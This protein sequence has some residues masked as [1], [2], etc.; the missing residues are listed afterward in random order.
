MRLLQRIR[1][2]SNAGVLAASLPLLAPAMIGCS[3]QVTTQDPVSCGGTDAGQKIPV[4]DRN[5]CNVISNNTIQPWNRFFVTDKSIYFDYLSDTCQPVDTVRFYSGDL[6]DIKP[7]LLSADT[8]Y[9]SNYSNGLL[10]FTPA[11]TECAGAW[12]TIK[13]FDFQNQAFR[14]LGIGS[15]N[16]VQNPSPA[17]L[18][19]N[20]LYYLSPSNV[21]DKTDMNVYD[22][23]DGSSKVIAADSPPI[24]MFNNPSASTKGIATF[25]SSGNNRSVDFLYVSGERKTLTSDGDYPAVSVGEDYL[26]VSNGGQTKVTIYAIDDLSPVKTLDAT[27]AFFVDNLLVFQNPS[28]GVTTYEP[29]SDKTATVGFDELIKGC[30]PDVESVFGGDSGVGMSP[31]LHLFQNDDK[32]VVV[33]ID[34]IFGFSFNVNGVSGSPIYRVIDLQ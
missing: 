26:T 7:A 19:K 24:Y 8:G 6:Y 16:P 34:T 3:G 5:G 20:K 10:A 30:G 28:N 18:A 25:S 9:M 4:G 13:I 21:T 29:A 11:Q 2:T 32:S 31:L 23:N 1:Q 27:F 12:K 22:L 17:I 15:Y 33:T 14:D